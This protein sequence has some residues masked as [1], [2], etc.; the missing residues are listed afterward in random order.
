MLSDWIQ[1]VASQNI[2][3][4]G[5]LLLLSYLLPDTPIGLQTKVSD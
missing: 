1:F 5:G 3:V 4:T 2:N